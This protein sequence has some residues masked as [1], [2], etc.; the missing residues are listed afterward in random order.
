[1]TARG[2]V[3]SPPPATGYPKLQGLLAEIPENSVVIVDH[4]NAEY[5]DPDVKAGINKK[6]GY[7]GYPILAKKTA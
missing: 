6:I 3:I 4:D 5:M 1:M 7:P 2:N